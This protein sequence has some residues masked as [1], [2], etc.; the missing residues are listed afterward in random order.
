MPCIDA[1]G[2]RLGR[3]SRR[4]AWL[5]RLL[6]FAGG[7]IGPLSL[8]T[9]IVTGELMAYGWRPKGLPPFAL[10]RG[11]HALAGEALLLVLG[12]RLVRGAWRFARPGAPRGSWRA[13]AAGDWPARLVGAG[14]GGCLLLLVGSGLVRHLR[15]RYGWSPLPPGEP[16]W[17]DVAHS[18]AVPYLYGFLLLEAYV[19]LRRWLPA[20]REYLVRQ[21]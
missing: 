13:W 21:Y 15:L 12:Y 4:L 1:L 3:L 20:L 18:A 14:G 7:L 9:L 19:R 11:M 17:W 8:I 16:A 10:L 2:E 6:V 5:E